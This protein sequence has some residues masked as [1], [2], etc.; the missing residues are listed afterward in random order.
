MMQI[1]GVNRTPQPRPLFEVGDKFPFKGVW[2]EI[3]SVE[4]N[5]IR[6]RPLGLT[7]KSKKLRGQR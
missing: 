5:E 4:P 1:Q 3:T 6:L 2:F 7:A